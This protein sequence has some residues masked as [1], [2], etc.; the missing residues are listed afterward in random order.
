MYFPRLYFRKCIFQTCIS[1]NLLMIM[2]III[3]MI[4]SNTD[5]MFM[6]IVIIIVVHSRWWWWLYRTQM[7]FMMMIAERGPWPLFQ[8]ISDKYLTIIKNGRR[9][10]SYEVRY[11]PGVPGA[12]RLKLNILNITS[13]YKTDLTSHIYIQTFNLWIILTDFEISSKLTVA[14]FISPWN[15]LRN[16]L[17]LCKLQV[18]LMAKIGMYLTNFFY[19]FKALRKALLRKHPDS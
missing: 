13:T 1:S 12:L 19:I 17:D 11:L 18:L 2:I 3:T 16:Y 9:G 10:Q 7:I 14:Y 6:I 15:E 5:M 8:I 4:A